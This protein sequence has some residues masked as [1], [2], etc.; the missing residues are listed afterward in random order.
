MS[1]EATVNITASGRVLFP[2]SLPES[3]VLPCRLQLLLIKWFFKKWEK[4]VQ[5]DGIL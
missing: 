2:V 5:K 1:G 4:E 3:L